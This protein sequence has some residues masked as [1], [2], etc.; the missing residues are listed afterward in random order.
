MHC[1]LLMYST[2][3]ISNH[4]R[5]SDLMGNTETIVSYSD[6]YIW[7]N[8]QLMC[9]LVHGRIQVANKITDCIGAC[10]FLFAEIFQSRLVNFFSTMC[11]L[12]TQVGGMTPRKHLAR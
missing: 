11:L 4:T 10:V 2:T 5:H 8:G 12:K 7:L 1:I 6:I 9:S 3:F